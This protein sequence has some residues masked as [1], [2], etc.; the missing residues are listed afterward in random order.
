MSHIIINKWNK[1]RLIVIDKKEGLNRVSLIEILLGWGHDFKN[2]KD[3]VILGL[4]IS[5]IKYYDDLNLNGYNFEQI[6]YNLDSI[7]TNDIINSKL[8]YYQT[9]IMVVSDVLRELFVFKSNRF[10]KKCNEDYM[11]VYMD[12][13]YIPIFECDKCLNTENL[14]GERV[15]LLKE[16]NLLPATPKVIKIFNIHPMPI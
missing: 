14:S 15:L 8:D 16:A 12:L 4:Y 5:Y 3:K 9:P 1:L 13:D 11:R 6:W 10:C 2:S 7:I